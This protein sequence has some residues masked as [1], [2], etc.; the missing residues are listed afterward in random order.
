MSVSLKTSSANS[1]SEL[2]ESDESPS[3][4]PYF[5]VFDDGIDESPKD[6]HRH[7]T[8]EEVREKVWQTLKD[9]EAMEDHVEE[10]N[11]LNYKLKQEI[12]FLDEGITREQDII[13]LLINEGIDHVHDRLKLMED[14]VASNV[15]AVKTTLRIL[16]AEDLAK[17][18][19][20][21]R[22]IDQL[23][24]RH[25]ALAT[26][27]AAKLQQV[28]IPVLIT[29]RSKYWLCLPCSSSV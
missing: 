8:S 17:Q 6:N 13:K 23:D 5:N 10:Q 21:D 22:A 1:L 3:H 27:T 29:F 26:S 11:A 28:R 12:T 15:S 2:W 4:D 7:W 25:K 24:A 19:Q 14:A 16:K 9:V 18:R 20:Q